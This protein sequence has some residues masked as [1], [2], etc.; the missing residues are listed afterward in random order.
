MFKVCGFSFSPG[1]FGLTR[2]ADDF[3]EEIV[4]CIYYFSDEGSV[5][6]SSNNPLTD[7]FLELVAKK[8]GQDVNIFQKE[9]DAA[10]KDKCL[11]VR[12]K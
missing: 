11:V 7:Q 9:Q 6:V 1:G 8:L 3:A 10:Y 12:I 2:Q 5:S 4:N